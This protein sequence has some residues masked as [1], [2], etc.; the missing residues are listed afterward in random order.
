MHAL[1]IVGASLFIG[2][3]DAVQKDKERLSGTWDLISLTQ[4]GNQPAKPGFKTALILSD[5]RH[6][7]HML[8]KVSSDS[9]NPGTS[10][11]SG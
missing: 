4:D 2:A 8:P 3:D 11:E 10:I 7:I 5:T 9:D 6:V 1:L